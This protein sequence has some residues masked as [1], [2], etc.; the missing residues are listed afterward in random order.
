MISTCAFGIEADAIKNP[1][2]DLVKCGR[3]VMT[4][5][6]AKS[7]MESIFLEIFLGDY[8]PGIGKLIPLMPPAFD[9]LFDIT[10]DIMTHRRQQ[11]TEHN[12][13][14]SRL[15]EMVKIKETDPNNDSVK[16]LNED[17]ITA[18]GVLFFIAGYETTANT[19]STFSYQMAKNPDIQEQLYEEIIDVM[20]ANDGKIDHETIGDMEFF[21]C[22][23]Q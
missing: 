14:V 13:F 18:Q 6:R 2:Q 21:G 15:I 11:N 1:D 4:E 12:D 10:K 5:F 22:G 16:E 7:W 19:L 23:S 9:K 3:E 8:I 17:I 20:E